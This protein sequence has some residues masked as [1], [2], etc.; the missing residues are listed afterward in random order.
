MRLRP[1][2][3]LAAVL[4]TANCSQPVVP[5]DHYYRL[6]IPVPTPAAAGPKLT[7]T[8]EVD[9][10][11]ADGLTAGR[12]IVYSQANQ[13]NA[14]FEYHYHFWIEPPTVMLQEA[15]VA[16]LRS[17]KLATVVVTPELRAQPD[18]VLSGK[19]KRLER[20]LGSKPTVVVEIELGLRRVRDAQLLHVNSYRIESAVQGDSV[21]AAVE[22]INRAVGEIYGRFAQDVSRI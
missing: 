4:A 5:E 22:A 1:W 8:L 13:P 7:G 18:H 21:A 9:R 20:V 12:P 17:A 16:Y 19:I 2:L 10:F 11:L 6:T 3:M 15:L 14:L